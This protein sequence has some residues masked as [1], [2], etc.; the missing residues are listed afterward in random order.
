VDRDD[1]SKQGNTLLP[2]DLFKTSAVINLETNVKCSRKRPEK[3]VPT[4]FVNEIRRRQAAGGRRQVPESNT[5]SITLRPV[6]NLGVRIS[7]LHLFGR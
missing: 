4:V 1:N 5:V 6:L 2:T 3:V 7:T